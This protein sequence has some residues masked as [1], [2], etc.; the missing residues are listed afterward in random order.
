MNFI[1]RVPLATIL[2]I[3]SVF[4]IFMITQGTM[5]LDT[6]IEAVVGVICVF[7]IVLAFTL[8]SNLDVVR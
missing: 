5:K 6:T 7:G 1:F 2:F 8:F 3:G 4:P